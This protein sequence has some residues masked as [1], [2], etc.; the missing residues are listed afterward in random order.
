VADDAVAF[1]LL[2]IGL[3]WLTS[4]NIL[5]PTVAIAIGVAATALLT[6]VAYKTTIALMLKPQVNTSMVGRKGIAVTEIMPDGMVLVE[7]ELWKASSQTPIEKGGAVIV[8]KAEGLRVVVSA[9]KKDE[10]APPRAP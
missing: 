8:T 7:G 4:E 6:I 10:G 1:I 5:A 2:V 9:E 3:A